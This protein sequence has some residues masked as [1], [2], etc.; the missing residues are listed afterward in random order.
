MSYAELFFRL[1]LIG[2]ALW[3]LNHVDVIDA[4]IKNIINILVVV[5]VLF[6]LA[7]VFL[8]FSPHLTSC[9]PVRR[10]N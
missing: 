2:V 8:G 6:W 1:I 5:V 3:V 4:R 9:G 7:D 10:I